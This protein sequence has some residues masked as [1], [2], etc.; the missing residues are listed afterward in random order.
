MFNSKNYRLVGWDFLLV[1]VFMFLCTVCGARQAAAQDTA[2]PEIPL[3]ASDTCP[4]IVQTALLAVDSFCEDTGRNQACY[5]NVRLEVE[6]QD[7]AMPFTFEQQGDRIDLSIVQKLTLSS[8]DEVTGEWGV[9]LMRVQADLPD[10]LPGQNITFLLFG[11]VEI[12]NA[13][14]DDETLNP[15]QAFRFRTGISDSLCADVPDSGILIQTPKGAGEIN[16]TANGVDITLSSTAYL[17]AEPGDDTVISLLEGQAEVQADGVTQTV[18]AGQQVTVP[19]DENLEAAAP[20]SEPLPYNLPTLDVLPVTQLEQPVEVVPNASGTTVNITGEGVVEAST[21]FSDQ[22]PASLSVDGD[23]G[24]SWFSA[25]PG[26]GGAPSLY[27]WTGT[28]DDLITSISVLSNAQHLDF[29]TGFGFGSV[30]VQV[31]DADG[32]VVF[33]ETVELAGT[34][35]PDVVVN[36]GVVG[37]SVVLTLSGHEDPS[38][39]GFSELQIEAVR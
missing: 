26:A 30:I 17:Q 3:A 4:A 21:T 29:P 15:M 37:R 2:T 38:C 7:D 5:G 35:D 1:L 14:E 33:E 8:M 16:L 11:D 27:R 23:R 10:T 19:T 13:V 28:R 39:G 20:P 22:F 18:T 24:T 36:P 32:N 9:A 31:L 34:P 25:G 12:E 6:P